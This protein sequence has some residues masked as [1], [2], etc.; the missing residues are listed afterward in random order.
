MPSYKDQMYGYYYNEMALAHHG[1]KGQKWGVRRYQNEDGTR[2]AAGRRHE[3]A[4]NLDSYG[5]LVG[6]GKQIRANYKKAKRSAFERSAKRNDRIDSETDSKLVKNEALRKSG[7]ITKK[8]AKEN[9]NKI[10]DEANK[11]Y[12]AENRRYKSEKQAAKAQYRE[13]RARMLENRAN[14]STAATNNNVLL[15]GLND[16]R[17]GRASFER[18]RRD[19]ASAKASGDK[20]AI[21]KARMNI[22]KHLVMGSALGGSTGIGAYNRYRDNG[23][24]VAKAV[25]KVSAGGSLFSK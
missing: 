15:R 10:V 5:T 14:Q 18:A 23:A 16:S 7:K 21:T 9:A 1:V 6:S 4:N 19:L 2:T 17:R 24:S 11:K 20:Q 3:Q 8:Q 25:L 13:N 22:G 12:D